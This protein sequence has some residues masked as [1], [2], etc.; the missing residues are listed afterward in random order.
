MNGLYEKF[1]VTRTDGRSAKG[2]RHHGCSY[3]VVDLDHDPLAADTILFYASLTENDALRID[4][5]RRSAELDSKK[6]TK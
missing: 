5:Q 2:E 6:D 3:F 4:L 1:E